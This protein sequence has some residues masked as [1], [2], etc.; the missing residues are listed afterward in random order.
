M[1]GNKKRRKFTGLLIV[2]L[3][4]LFIVTPVFHAQ[5]DSN[6]IQ[7]HYAQ[8][9]PRLSYTFKNQDIFFTNKSSDSTVSK[10][11]FSTGNQFQVGGIFSYRWINIGYSFSLS[12]TSTKQNMD[13]RFST[14]YRPFQVQ[15][16]LSYLQNLNYTLSYSKNDIVL[17]TVLSQRE[18]DISI[19]T[20][21]LRVDYVFNYRKYV[22]A[23]GSTPVSRQL[24]SAGSWVA[25]AAI[26]NDK[27]SLDDLSP[28]AKPQFDSIN[29]FTNLMVNSFDLGFGYG[30]SWVLNKHWTMSFVEIPNIG[31]EFIQP[32]RL[33]PEKYF[34]TAGFVNHF[35]GSIL[36]A[37]NRF[38][39]GLVV[40]NSVSVS[41][42]KNSAYNNVYTSVAL[43]GGWVFDS[44]K[45]RRKKKRASK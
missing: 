39:T 34:F 7:S 19:F 33:V 9:V 27:V 16:N 18:S 30:Y 17:D 3:L 26:S 2:Q 12:P 14:S 38:F 31:F 37:K 44:E 4:L 20:S 24:K 28:L 22:Y 25:S 23:A 1:T 10:A 8:V 40:Y 42:V 5:T 32:G 29:G 43:Y 13:F 15:F 41:Q 6:Y 21:R 36:Y 35:K 45:F 11:S